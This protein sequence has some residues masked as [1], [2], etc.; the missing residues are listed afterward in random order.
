M[1]WYD[2]KSNTIFFVGEHEV[3]NGTYEFPKGLKNI[4][5]FAF[6]SKRDLEKL[7]IPDG[8]TSIGERAFVDCSGLKEITIPDS[9]SE[10]GE[11][12]FAGCSNIQTINLR[13]HN[14]VC[15]IPSNQ[16]IID[17]MTA[18]INSFRNFILAKNELNK[19]FLPGGYII[20]N[21]PKNMIKNFYNHASSWLIILNRFAAS[22]NLTPKDMFEGAKEDLFKLC[23]VSGVFSE[24]E[25]ERTRAETFLDTKIIGHIGQADFCKRFAGLNTKENGFIPEYARVLIRE[26]N[27]EF[28]MMN[29][30]QNVLADSYNKFPQI[31]TKFAKEE[32]SG[33]NKERI[34][35]KYI[36]ECLASEKA[37][38]IEK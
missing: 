22:V 13:Y 28:M 25:E 37:K 24:N 14:K 11:N 3:K 9:V 20:L 1:H 32:K 29:N 6:S 2:K 16:H 21:T 36:K 4:G 27:D 15:K 34:T 12:A 31:K 5:A 8:V 38:K 35:Q 23:L 30:Y 33:N 18:D 19:T 7:D 10:I 26:Y 17:V